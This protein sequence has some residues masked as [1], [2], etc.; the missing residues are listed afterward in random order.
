MKK[1]LILTAAIAMC[2]A[3][4]L[5]SCGFFTS[6][7]TLA[8]IVNTEWTDPTGVAN[9]FLG[10]GEKLSFG[11]GQI[12]A[13]SDRYIVLSKTDDAGISTIE[14]YDIE[15]STYTPVLSLQNKSER[16]ESSNIT[17]KTDHYVDI[18]GEYYA[19]L[20]VEYDYSSYL[21]SSYYT[22][23][24]WVNFDTAEYVPSNYRITN[25]DSSL[26]AQYTLDF[27]SG[28]SSTPVGNV[29]AETLIEW[30]RQSYMNYS[31]YF[32]SEYFKRVS[33]LSGTMI[34]DELMIK[35]TSLYRVDDNGNET[36]V[37]ELGLT[38]IPTGSVIETE[39]Y[40]V[41]RNSD[42]YSYAYSYIYYDKDLNYV[43]TVSVPQYYGSDM[44]SKGYVMSNGNLLVQTTKPVASD[45]KKYDFVIE[46]YKF[47][48]ET[49]MV[50][51][52]TGKKTDLDFDFIIS[53]LENTYETDAEN[54][55]WAEDLEN[56]AIVYPID[57]KTINMSAAASDWISISNKG[58]D[59][60]SVKFMSD[61]ASLPVPCEDGYFEAEDI[62]GNTVI[63]DKEGIVVA[64]YNT[65]DATRKHNYIVKGDII[66]DILGR[67]VFDKKENGV[68]SF[69]VLAY[70]VFM[71]T[72]TFGDQTEYRIYVDGN[73]KNTYTVQNSTGVISGIDKFSV[74]LNGN[75]YYVRSYT[76]D[77]T[78][79]YTYE[80]YNLNGDM[81][82]SYS[83]ALT[84]S[85]ESEECIM[86]TLDNN[87]TTEYY[88]FAFNSNK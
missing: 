42:S 63:F 37:K 80:Y 70:N 79:P 68:D 12:I 85:S 73:V 54:N 52:A 36:Y 8:D 49:Y 77:L 81:I 76:A 64:R 3:M 14:I 82:G 66:Y 47:D 2:V 48:L 34:T 31:S 5:S 33:E 55:F 45:A 20:K 7:S 27:Y 15:Y 44:G 13:N 23:G 40:Y 30:D 75:A 17:K 50:D 58:K 24:V 71:T 61:L 57:D 22:S 26:G 65:S 16:A 86:A 19:V 39:R 25:Y 29:P 6:K 62:S 87:G 10:Y 1:K 67:K 41:E 21:P 28:S 32:N 51:P 60:G 4:L 69:E 59:K 56:I 53:V 83:G 18:V 84:V 72:D 46:D 43:T 88:M 35:G 74:A 78:S 38:S 11:E 9:K